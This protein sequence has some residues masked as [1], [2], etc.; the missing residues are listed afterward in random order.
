M[1]LQKKEI[2][3]K[4]ENEI[5]LAI[6]YDKELQSLENVLG[7]LKEEN[8]AIENELRKTKEDNAVS[9]KEIQI[10]CNEYKLDIQEMDKDIYQN[11]Q[12]DA[13][14]CKVYNKNCL[15]F[16]LLIPYISENKR[17]GNKLF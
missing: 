6:E 16:K 15:R 4:D 2:E 9:S 10:K 7:S 17:I 3:E 8:S 12:K 5:H 1:Q 11:I 13:E 14:L